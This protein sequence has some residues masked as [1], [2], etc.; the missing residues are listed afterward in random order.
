MK[1][2]VWILTLVGTV[3]NLALAGLLL[4][5]HVFAKIVGPRYGHND[6]IFSISRSDTSYVMST[7]PGP[8]VLILV[9]GCL[10]LLG[11]RRLL[12]N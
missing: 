7:H 3:P 8:L 9:G 4:T 5:A 6:F 12:Q 11:V 1:T 2:A 10:L